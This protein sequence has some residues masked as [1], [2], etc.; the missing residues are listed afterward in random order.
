MFT[1]PSFNR[2]ESSMKR[3]TALFVMLLLA[4]L[5]AA[6][7]AA[8]LNDSDSDDRVA[9][10]THDKSKPSSTSDGNN[11]PPPDD[12]HPSATTTAVTTA[13]PYGSVLVTVE[14]EVVNNGETY[15]GEDPLPTLSLVVHDP[16][17]QTGLSEERIDYS[18]GVAKDGK[19]N[20]VS[21]DH[22]NYFDSHNR[23]A[24]TLDTLSEEKVL[25]LTF[26]NGYEYNDLTGKILDI[27][28]EKDVPAAF[29]CTLD[30]IEDEPDYIVRMINEG[31]IV[32]NHSTT[33]PVMS[34]ISKEQMAAEILGVENYLRVNFG[35]SS[36]YFRFPSGTYTDEALELV[37][38]IGFRSVFWSNAHAD[39][40]TAAQ[41]TVQKTF[42][43]ITSRLHPGSVI[44]LHA[45]SQSNTDALA[46]IIDYARSEGYVFRS[47][48]EYPG[49]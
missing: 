9:D 7:T 17:N 8:Q 20:Q 6:C 32:G 35:Y 49:W 41:P 33:H 37:D 40:D 11:D 44:L 28:K 12:D 2:K 29:F 47:L 43:T 13:S 1:D 23:S 14:P 45:V 48:D 21:V 19:P 4:T 5:L 38:S 18:F 27:L 46:D 16:E 3:L 24:L 26:D 39:W 22:Q 30:Y 36:P 25:Y 10:S 34:N 42:D 15:T 31:H